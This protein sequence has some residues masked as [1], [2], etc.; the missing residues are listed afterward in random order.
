MEANADGS[1]ATTLID[2]GG[3]HY[4]FCD[5]DR[6]VSENDFFWISGDCG[7]G[8]LTPI[9]YEGNSSIAQFV[10]STPNFVR[11]L[12]VDDADLKLFISSPGTG[13]TRLERPHT[14]RPNPGDPSMGGAGEIFAAP[15]PPPA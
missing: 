12:L 7:G 13:S 8:S 11:R 14:G 3:T 10:F 6:S 15:A 1:A 2:F 9:V 5:L 4:Q